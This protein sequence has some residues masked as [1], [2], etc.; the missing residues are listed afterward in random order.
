MVAASPEVLATAKSNL[1]ALE[2]AVSG[3]T[4]HVSNIPKKDQKQTLVALAT[5]TELANQAILQSQPYLIKALPAI[6]AA[7]G[8]K[9]SSAETRNAA[10]LAAKTICSKMSPNA[11]REVLPYLH[12]AVDY[13]QKWQT[14]ACALD[15]IAG[16][17][18]HAPDQLGFA[19]PDVIP[20][21]SQCVVDL[22]T[23]VS[24][25]AIKAL[26]AA[27]D[28]VGNH[29]IEHLTEYI[30]RS[31]VNPEETEELMHKLAGVTFVQSVESPAL[32]M[33][34]P[35][36]LRGLAS[37]KKATVR[38]SAVIIENMSK[39]VDDPLDAA[40]FLPKLLPALTKAADMLSDPEAR[41][42]AERSLGQLERL[43]REVEEAK[44]RQQHID[45]D[46]VLKTLESKF[47]KSAEFD[48]Y[49][50]SVASLCCSLM[51]I[52]K[53]DEADWVEISEHLSV[54]SKKVTP[55]AITKLKEECE[56]MC[57]PLPK[58]DD[59]ADDGAEMLCD[60]TFTLAYGTKILLHNTQLKLKRGAKYGLLGGNDS[61][62]T[63]LMRSIANG[64]LEGFPD[65]SEVRTVF[66]EADILGELSHLSC[67]DYVMM[68]ERLKG[69]DRNKVLEVMGS[70]GF[71]EDGKAKPSHPVST[72]SGGWRMK[73]AMARAML[74][75]ADILLL[76]EPTNH[77]DVINVKWVKNYI[78]SLK[79]VTCI[80]VS[81]DS[82]F[83]NDCCTNIV[84]ITNLKL[85]QFRGN[86]NK[87]IES[88][89]EA[90]SYFNIKASKLSFNFPQPGAIHG[91]KSRT[92]ALMKMSNCFYTYP[93]R[94][95]P[96]LH[97]I[98]I[99][100]SMASRV[101]CVGENGAGK[102][103]MIK[104]LTGELVPQVG[105]VWKHN[106]AR[107]AYV[108]QHAFHHIEEHLD[109]TPNEYIRWR[110]E[111]GE[112]K[113]SL[114]KVS[115]VFTPEEEKLQREPFKLRDQQTGKDI[116]R[117]IDYLPGNRR[118]TK[119][120]EY[121]YDVRFVGESAKNEGTFLPYKVLVKQGW[122]K[123]CKAIDLRIAQ[124]EGMAQR[125][126]SAVNVEKHLSDVG[127]EPEFASHYRM[128]ALSGGQKVKVVLA[129]SLW[130]Q[131]H[132]L[133][134]DEPTN[135]L[136][137]ESLGALAKAIEGF[138]G[139]V[140]IISH[141]NEFV[142]TLCT[143]EW[144]MDA[145]HLTTKGE[146]GAW[147]DKEADK[148]DD[149][150]VIETMTDA[151]GN[152]TKV[153]Q[154]KK[155]TKRE[156][157]AFTKLVKAKIESG[158]DM[159]SD[160]EDFANQ[161][162]P[163][164][165]SLA[166]T[167]I[168][169]SV[170]PRILTENDFVAPIALK[171]PLCDVNCPY[172]YF[173]P[174]DEKH[175]K[176][177]KAFAQSQQL[178]YQTNVIPFPNEIEMA[179][180]FLLEYENIK[181]SSLL[182]FVSFDVQE[183]SNLTKYSVWKEYT[184]TSIYR[185]HVLSSIPALQ[186]ALDQAIISSSGSNTN[187]NKKFDTTIK[188]IKP[189]DKPLNLRK[190]EEFSSSTSSIGPNMN[191][192]LI[193]DGMG[194]IESTYWISSFFPMIF[195]SLLAA[196][197]SVGAVSFTGFVMKNIVDFNNQNISS[198]IIFIVTFIF[199]LSLS[200]VGLFLSSIFS[201]PLY[202]SVAKGLI[203]IGMVVTNL[204]V[205]TNFPYETNSVPYFL[206]IST[207]AWGK[208]LYILLPWLGYGQI[209]NNMVNIVEKSNLNN[210]T[211]SYVGF[212]QFSSSLC[213]LAPLHESFTI[214]TPFYLAW[215]QHPSSMLIL[216]FIILSIPFFLFLSWYFNQMLE[217]E[218]GYSLEFYFL[219]TKAYWIGIQKENKKED[220]YESFGDLL[221]EERALSLKSDSVRTHKLSKVY[222]TTS[223]VKEFTIK[224]EKGN[225]YSILG[226]N[227]C[228]K[229]TTINML[230]G[231]TSPTYGEAFLFGLNVKTDM[232]SIRLKMGTCAQD[233]L[234]YSSLTAAEHISFY[235]R[236]RNVNL[237]NLSLKE[238]VE[239]KLSQVQL[240]EAAHQKV[241]GFS[242]GMM[243]RLS[244]ILSTVGD[245]LSIIFLDEPTTGLDP[246][247]KRGIWKVIEEL[248]KDKIVVLTTHSMEEADSLSD[249]I[250]I[251]HAGKIKASGT[252]LFLKNHFGDGYQISMLRKGIDEENTKNVT[253]SLENWIKTVLPGSTIVSSAAGAVNV[254]VGKGN[255]VQLTSFLKALQR[256]KE[257]EWSVSNSTLE[258]VFLKLCSLNDA[259]NVEVTKTLIC[260]L[261]NI[262]NTETVTLFTANGIKVVVSDIICNSCALGVT[263]SKQYSENDIISFESFWQLQEQVSEE[264]PLLNTQQDNAI[265]KLA[266]SSKNQS[267]SKGILGSQ[268][269]GIVIKNASLDIRMKKTNICSALCIIL[270]NIILALMSM[271]MFSS[272]YINEDG[273]TCAGATFIYSSNFD[274]KISCNPEHFVNQTTNNQNSPFSGLP[275]SSPQQIVR[276]LLSTNSRD[277]FLF[278]PPLTP[279]M[280]P[281]SNG[282]DTVSVLRP[283]FWYKDSLVSGDIAL[284]SL[285]DPSF[286]TNVAVNLST[287]PTTTPDRN[288]QVLNLPLSAVN[289]QTQNMED[290]FSQKQKA[291]LPEKTANAGTCSTLIGDKTNFVLLTSPAEFWQTLN[292]TYPDLG[293]DIKNLNV[294]AGLVSYDIFIYRPLQDDSGYPSVFFQND[295]ECVVA[296][297]LYSPYNSK[298]MELQIS[299]IINTMSNALQ[300][301]KLGL[302]PNSETVVDTVWK[303]YPTIYEGNSFQQ[304]GYIMTV[305]ITFFATLFFFPRMVSLFVT[306]RSQNLTEMLRIQGL[307]PF[308]YWLGNYIYGFLGCLCINIFT[309][310][311]G[312]LL[313][314]PFQTSKSPTFIVI[315]FILW[316]HSLVCMAILISSIFK[317]VI[318]SSLATFMIYI[319]SSC[320]ASFMLITSNTSTGALSELASSIFPFIAFAHSLNICF[321]SGKLHVLGPVIGIWIASSTFV[322]LLGIYLHMIQ[323]GKH[324]ASIDPFFGLFKKKNS[325]LPH[326]TDA[327]DAIT[328]PDVLLEQQTV[329]ESLGKKND[330][331]S[332]INIGH[333]Q[334]VFGNKIAVSDIS[335]NVKFGETFGLLGPNGAGKST[336]INCFTGLASPTNGVIEVAGQD[337]KTVKEL[338]RLIGLCPQFDTVWADL[339]IE[340]H[341]LFYCRLRGIPKNKIRGTVR[342]IAEDVG[343]DGDPF[344]QLASQ[345]SGGM[346]RR[347]SIA[348][349]MTASPS[350]LVLDEPTT[351]LDPD[352]RQNIWKVINKISQ[353]P[354]RSIIITTHSMEEADALCSRIGIVVNGK[355]KVIGN[356][357][358]LKNKFGD[359][360]KLS[361]KIS[362]SEVFS[363]LSLPS[364]QEFT[365]KE[366]YAIDKVKSLIKEKISR[367][368]SVISRS[369]TPIT[370]VLSK[371]TLE[372]TEVTWNVIL[373]FNIP[374][375]VGLDVA[376]VFSNLQT[377]AAEMNM[378]DWALNQTTLED[379]FVRVAK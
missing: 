75:N 235:A 347:L 98:S 143:E 371:I 46:R 92:K 283:R 189:E 265:E 290:Y 349:A 12:E 10:E 223:A 329:M 124:T 61:G 258:Q 213:N 164:L 345:M 220:L 33:V 168:S 348:I 301:K 53:F 257:V 332:A 191:A 300:K 286:F 318:S 162:G 144:I 159:D 376:S 226:H 266:V 185:E 123:A 173:Q 206:Q 156:E 231:V 292:N 359:G 3:L 172:I 215:Q 91:I 93:T 18:D 254:G 346:R 256:E 369:K 319:L 31:V 52:R 176:I 271:G 161:H 222:K 273:G 308:T 274:S 355:M 242:G 289:V 97:N 229:T 41:S 315:A 50:R 234:L 163:I 135:Y 188:F 227:G 317:K 49:L 299:V 180:K 373:Q 110:Y 259:V 113:E 100:V 343:L 351:G 285:L 109:K 21:V 313:I 216:I 94:D 181:S 26:T 146:S 240:L 25:S 337:I 310:I 306:E 76:D 81:H 55:E 167:A 326:I 225:V 34:S 208:I 327:E 89:P 71:V 17:A 60:C 27:C 267:S 186:L 312:F 13:E 339:T 321:T 68:D 291:L 57:K 190:I 268:I 86:L 119:T 80:M 238:Y 322:G 354:G 249:Y 279:N 160:E 90:K 59:D 130:N 129:A 202:I 217:T 115:M 200:S 9:K 28:V 62:K 79:H 205:F 102:S 260:R 275:E 262:N 196:S 179:N 122:E 133:I 182:A 11:L 193:P 23:Q 263:N 30:V 364:E 38:Q 145:G 83:L 19:L 204:V 210:N 45:L 374:N 330:S 197:V 297:E 128:S 233:D 105:E 245:D 44:T 87:F 272:R 147:M 149:S 84:Q 361:M 15:I 241:G 42:V 284:Q 22:K 16:F 148:I 378:V 334:K 95:T 6:L 305:L 324:T 7:L 155:L 192:Y 353:D 314:K 157:K 66:V 253:K 201:K 221:I 177:M 70:V 101:G 277:N 151:V 20:E 139:G 150:A 99:Q 198:A 209:F 153:K 29:D 132:I 118:P 323:P 304:V 78:N 125:T 360:L 165:V 370:T 72:L 288:P 4:E 264:S 77:L 73:L 239:G 169:S 375:E 243:R 261:C 136:D 108:A 307:R 170:A 58:K 282:I 320:I 56:A 331:K 48:T 63:T 103:T 356:Q 107:I 152:V 40:P 236:F 85:K 335:L 24:E 365:E 43:E 250:T 82:G 88:N 328:D 96:T 116:K 211:E 296:G 65:P 69:L 154:R 333:L 137:R 367:S 342:K 199:C 338:W 362:L 363:P 39:L 237:G 32:A 158:A 117:T 309:M 255:S 280:V 207:S 127:L 352:T 212:P 106:Q 5:F 232:N 287:L 377:Y 114:V 219:F 126:L 228:G 142:S 357:V 303:T 36:L 195:V 293:L 336:T 141:H 174:N 281:N 51:S 224:M 54:I 67:I 134:L 244:V 2:K 138:L 120:G 178:P 269:K 295:T 325:L 358:H 187:A 246:V 366:N 379:V 175:T 171:L 341:L 372:S 248:K 203:G 166:N 251:M 311:I 316:A 252:P 344:N 64:A 74:Q 350:I 183:N 340:Q 14:R 121:E 247:S 104:V 298:D 111:F 194:L 37:T 35:L 278:M 230:S 270:L 47:G 294:E 302:A 8:D 218:Q 140:V 112:D 184:S 131:P 1:K 214:G 276:T 368:A